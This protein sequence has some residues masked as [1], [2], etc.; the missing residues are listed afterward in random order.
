MSTSFLRMAKNPAVE[1]ARDRLRV[2]FVHDEKPAPDTVDA[3]LTS[4]GY[5]LFP[6]WTGRE[7]LQ[8]FQRVRPDLILLELNLSDMDGKQVLRRLRESTSIPIV[9]ISVRREESEQI[10]CLDAGADDYVV[11][12]FPMGVLLAR[13]RA[14]L[15]RA[16]GI[17]RNQVFKT[18][19]LTMDFSRR[20]V[21]IWDSQ[22]RLTATEYSLLKVLASHAGMVKTHFQLIHEVWGTMQ[23]Q[24][25][26][27][28]LRVTVSNL[29]RKLMCDSPLIVTEAGVG[30]RLQGDSEGIRRLRLEPPPRTAQ[31]ISPNPM[32]VARRR[33]GTCSSL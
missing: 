19:G 23:Y 9:V 3:V 26:V 21:F 30:Y 15:R 6:A 28:L 29:R 31:R 13:L 12:P 11:K 1:I 8:T 32:L 24:D 18:G 2:L 27:H 7:A 25:A 17:P 33:N 10:D 22:V 16:F 5:D 20:T 14:A 4:S